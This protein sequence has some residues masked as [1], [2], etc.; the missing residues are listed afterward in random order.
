MKTS[1]KLNIHQ[2]KESNCN[3]L[4]QIALR[5]NKILIALRKRYY[6][7]VLLTIPILMLSEM[8][9]KFMGIN[10][11]FHFS[12]YIIF[13][14]TSVIFV[15]GGWPFI[16]GLINEVRLKNP[17]MMFTIGTTIIIAYIY[18]IPII[19]GLQKIEFF[20]ELIAL[21]LI[22]ILDYWIQIKSITKA[23]KDM[24]IIKQ[25]ISTEKLNKIQKVAFIG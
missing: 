24:A 18:S 2:S 22:I 16:K 13:T 19:F 20:S 9:R 3:D 11:E 21:I 4:D 1:E 10:G 14:L 17:G 5:D 6:R 15:Y 8:T 7:V 25:S 12:S 23:S